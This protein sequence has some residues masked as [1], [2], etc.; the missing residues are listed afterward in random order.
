VSTRLNLSIVRSQ[1]SFVE[2]DLLLS[3]LKYI[4][5]GYHQDLR[6]MEGTRESLLKQII[7]WAADGSKQTDGRNT[8]WI[9]GLPG[10]GKT[11]LAHSICARLH[12]QRMLAA[13]IFCQRDDPEL[14]DPRNI[15]PT[16][17]HN[18]AVIFS[19]FR[20]AVAGRLHKDP[21]V[22]PESIQ[23][24]VFLDSI[25]ALPRHPKKHLRH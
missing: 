16:L 19:P 8:Y 1:Q 20:R 5:T 22:T 3:H 24:T 18:L 7:A 17:I 15:L 10:T 4:E 12:D 23:H 21:D 13:A 6:C 2:L 14:S 9:H 11:S 25:R